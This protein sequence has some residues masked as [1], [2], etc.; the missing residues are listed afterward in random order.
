MLRALTKED[1]SELVSIEAATQISPWSEE[2]FKRCQEVGSIGWVA[3]QSGQ[4]IGFIIVMFQAPDAH[5][6]NLCVHPD[7]QHQGIGQQLLEK[8]LNTAKEQGIG[9][10]YL[11]VRISNRKAINLYKKMGFSQVG[12]RKDYYTDQTQTGHE[13]ALVF[14]KDLQAL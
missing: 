13:N 11:E 6:L 8:A 7:Y 12:E 4:V 2:V 9:V 10:A 1:L 5:I 14:A 3:E